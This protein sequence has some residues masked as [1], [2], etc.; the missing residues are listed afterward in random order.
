[1]K[2]LQFDRA[3][4]IRKSIWRSQIG[5]ETDNIAETYIVLPSFMDKWE[6]C[7]AVT[8]SRDWG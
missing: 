7:K 1:M 2:C 5:A 6:Q 8:H 3:R 4:G